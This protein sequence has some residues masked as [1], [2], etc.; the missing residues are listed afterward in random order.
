MSVKQLASQAMENLRGTPFVFALLVINIIV[1]IGFAF[2]LYD[3]SKSIARRDAIIQSCI[4][5][6]RP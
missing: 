1:L 4:D 3:V 2:T 5:R 6:S